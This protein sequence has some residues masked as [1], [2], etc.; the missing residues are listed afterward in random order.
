MRLKK[1][2]KRITWGFNPVTR[3]VASKKKYVRVKE[4]SFLLKEHPP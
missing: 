3:T 2:K 1:L 4:K